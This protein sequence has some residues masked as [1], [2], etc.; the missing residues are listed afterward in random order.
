[1]R[2]AIRTI[3]RC[4]QTGARLDCKAEFYRFDLMT[5]MFDPGPI[6]HPRIPIYISG[7]NQYMC[8]VAGEVCEGVHVRPFNSPKSRREC[9]LPCT[10]AG[11]RK[12][13]RKRGDFTYAT[14]T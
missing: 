4:R 12:S 14:S 9:V 3:R 2:L 6:E 1:E 7:V 5:P 8:R 10:E 13:G 11:M